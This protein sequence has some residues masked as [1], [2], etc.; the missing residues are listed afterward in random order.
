MSTYILSYPIVAPVLL[1]DLTLEQKNS[2]KDQMGQM[3]P[4]FMKLDQLLPLFYA[5]T[6]NAEA[7]VRLIRM[8]CILSN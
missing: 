5:L 8:V 6:N 7:T 2:V 1:G 3:M 4:L